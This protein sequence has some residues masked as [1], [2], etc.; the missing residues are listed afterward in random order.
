MTENQRKTYEA[1]MCVKASLNGSI[2]YAKTEGKV[3]EQKR[4]REKLKA[5]GMSYSEIDILLD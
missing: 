1:D 4:I 2:A 5:S 3:E